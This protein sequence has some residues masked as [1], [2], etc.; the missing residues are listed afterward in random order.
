MERG[1]A[2]PLWLGGAVALEGLL[3]HPCIQHIFPRRATPTKR[4]GVVQDRDRPL[5]SKS[6]SRQICCEEL[7]VGGPDRHPFEGVAHVLFTQ[8]DW[9]PWELLL[10]P[11]DSPGDLGVLRLER[12]WMP[13]LV[14]CLVDGR[15]V[16]YDAPFVRHRPVRQHLRNPCHWDGDHPPKELISH[17]EAD[18]SPSLGRILPELSCGLLQMVPQAP[19]SFTAFAG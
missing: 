19:H 16:P 6:C 18:Q 9:H 2:V 8:K 1:L 3:R 5:G 15:S 17:V 12:R 4:Q 10:P 14:T 13:F 11:K 7:G